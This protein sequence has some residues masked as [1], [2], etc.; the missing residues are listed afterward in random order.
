MEITSKSIRYNSQIFPVKNIANSRLVEKPHRGDETKAAEGRNQKVFRG[1]L[2]FLL[3]AILVLTVMYLP[4]ASTRRTSFGEEIG[5]AFIFSFLTAIIP[6]ILIHSIFVKNIFME[7]TDPPLDK[8]YGIELVTNSGSSNLFWNEDEDFVRK[9]GEK[10]FAVLEGEDDVSLTVNLDNRTILDASST[11]NNTTIN[12]NYDYSIQVKQY[13]GIQP[14][15]MSYF[16]DTL[17]KNL[18]E[19]GAKIESVNSPE[20]QADMQALVSEFN[21]KKPNPSVISSLW[22][23][24]KQLGDGCG[25][26]NDLIATGGVV[27][28]ALS[29]L[30]SS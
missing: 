10:I 25:L 16:T 2:V 29:L 11:T 14:E 18:E 17:S 20:L 9:V 4:M 30:G 6:A 26:A 8:I 7:K 19:L 28:G 13:E 5:G 22:N 23:R 27:M 15:A 3:V 24:V 12:H 1:Y 21:E